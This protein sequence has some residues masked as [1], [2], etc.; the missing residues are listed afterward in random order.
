MAEDFE[1]EPRLISSQVELSKLEN[2]VNIVMI[3]LG[4]DASH[5]SEL[6]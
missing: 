4:L 1:P 6:C 3:S 2:Q 5:Y